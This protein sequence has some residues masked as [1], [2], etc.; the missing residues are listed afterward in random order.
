MHHP[1]PLII[2][3]M[4]R[5]ATSGLFS[6]IHRKKMRPRPSAFRPRHSLA[7]LETLQQRLQFT[8]RKV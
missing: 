7:R 4:E 3:N 6:E 2:E 5:A 1:L 8:S